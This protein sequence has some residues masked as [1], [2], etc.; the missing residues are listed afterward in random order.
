MKKRTPLLAIISEFYIAQMTN[1]LFSLMNPQVN[2]QLINIVRLSWE[3]DF[4]L[5]WASCHFLEDFGA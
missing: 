1:Y 2:L 5:C 3:A 4:I